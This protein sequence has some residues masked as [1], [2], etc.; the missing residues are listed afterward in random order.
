L[1]EAKAAEDAR[2]VREAQR[3]EYEAA[4]RRREAK[5]RAS[6][7]EKQRYA[8][9]VMDAM[10]EEDRINQ[11]NAQKRRMRVLEH[12]READRLAEIKFAAKER[13]LQA[14]RQALEAQRRDRAAYD[15]AVDA[16]RERLIANH[17]ALMAVGAHSQE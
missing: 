8:R 11:M 7:E 2:K 13:E 12:K 5:E 3:L 9:E 14:E 16:E 6:R 1:S 15:A 4:V 17:R 10:A